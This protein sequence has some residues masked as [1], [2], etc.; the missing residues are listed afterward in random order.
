MRVAHLNPGIRG[1]ATYAI[2]LYD[3]FTRNGD[4]H[5]V[6]CEAHWT[7]KDI[8]AFEAKP[9]LLAGVLPWIGDINA[10]YAKLDEFKP[11]IIHHH[12]PSGRFDFHVDKLKARLGVPVVNTIH[13]SVGSKKYFVDK[14]MHGWFQLQRRYFETT[15]RYIAISKFVLRQLVELGIPKEK[16]VL[17]YAGVDQQ[18]YEPLPRPERDWL[19]ITFCGQITPEKGVDLLIRAVHELSSRRKVKLNLIGNGTHFKRW[20]SWTKGWPEIHW[21]GFLNAPE[22]VAEAYAITDVVV[23]PT[24]WDEAFSYVPIESLSSGTPVIASA[25]GGNLEAIQDGVTGFHFEKNDWRG[26][27][28]ILEDADI[29]RLREMGRAGRA[30][31]EKKHTLELFGQEYRKVY[32][33]L[34]SNPGKLPRLKNKARSER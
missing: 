19:D 34:L 28:R 12:H 1:L 11:D 7:K 13:V 27:L 3:Y 24:R 8:G 22:K 6:L 26:L 29:D 31:C 16:I 25:A 21:A 14:V 10:A 5:L 15:D 4:E 20:K 9:R 18:V 17:L 32:E 33:N 2:N 30:Y 23:L